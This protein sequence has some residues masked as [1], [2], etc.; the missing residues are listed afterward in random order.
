MQMVQ[1]PLWRERAAQSRV[2]YPLV[3]MVDPGILDVV[4]FEGA[5]DYTKAR[6]AYNMLV[7]TLMTI[8]WHAPIL[9]S[10]QPAELQRLPQLLARRPN[11]LHDAQL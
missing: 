7:Q 3:E 11:C 4:L 2:L 10:C 6:T 9:V 5:D 1:R 8:N